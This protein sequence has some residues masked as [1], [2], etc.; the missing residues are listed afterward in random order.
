[1]AEREAGRTRE[2]VDGMRAGDELA[3]RAFFTFIDGLKGKQLGKD[4]ERALT[5]VVSVVE[6][7]LPTEAQRVYAATSP[8]EHKKPGR[9]RKIVSKK[10]VRR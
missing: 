1:M 10:K 2:L 7:L 3:M 6:L 4:G 5:V 9:S 8:R